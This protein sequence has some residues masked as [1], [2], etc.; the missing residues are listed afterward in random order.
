MSEPWG[1][2]WVISSVEKIVSKCIINS[3]VDVGP[4]NGTYARLLGPTLA[5]CYWRG[6]EA[7][8]PYVEEY[9]LNDLYD[10]LI[11]ADARYVSS[12]ALDADFVIFGDV[13][14]HMSRLDAYA[15]VDRAIQCRSYPY[16]HMILIASP[17]FH[18]HQDAVNGNPFECHDEHNFFS[19]EMAERFFADLDVAAHGYRVDSLVGDVVGYFLLRKGSYTEVDLSATSES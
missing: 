11:V 3:V 7:W 5:P 19:T 2:D 18:M 16:D 6:V 4:G 12:I 13:L 10:N 9:G 15:L 17:V 14:E 8:G 1:K